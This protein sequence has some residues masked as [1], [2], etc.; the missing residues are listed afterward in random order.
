MIGQLFT[1]WDMI[2]L[3]VDPL[4]TSVF[5]SSASFVFK[6][7]SLLARMYS[8]SETH[9]RSV[10]PKRP[11]G[12]DRSHSPYSSSSSYYEGSRSRSRS[13]S[14]RQ[15][16]GHRSPYRSYDKHRYCSRSPSPRRRYHRRYRSRSPPSR[17]M[18]RPINRNT[19]VYVGNLPF[20]AKWHHLKDVGR[21]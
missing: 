15:P 20:D 11:R 19:R 18:S 6:S 4:P 9:G 16:H 13:F 12:R 7:T 1:K 3:R 17:R 14:R 21:K 2:G 8:P 5:F 10:S